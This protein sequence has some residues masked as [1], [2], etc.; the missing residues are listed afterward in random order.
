MRHSLR[1][2]KEKW[3]CKDQK[4]KQEKKKERK[5]VNKILQLRKRE[6]RKRRNV[7]EN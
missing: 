7:R 1:N 6:G 2:Y 5:N 3:K 4:T